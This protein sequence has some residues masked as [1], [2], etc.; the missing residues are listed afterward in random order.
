MTQEI[1]YQM[2]LV[3]DAR[4]LQKA[5]RASWK[6]CDNLSVCKGVEIEAYQT[7]LVEART[8]LAELEETLGN[9]RLLEVDRYIAKNKRRWMRVRSGVR[10]ILSADYKLLVTLTFTDDCLGSTTAETR[11][12][13]VRKYLAS[14]SDRYIANRDFGKQNGREHYHAIVRAVSIDFTAWKHGTVNAKPINPRQDKK[15]ACSRLSKYIDKL[16]AHAVKDTAC[17]RLIWSRAPKVLEAD[18]EE[19]SIDEAIDWLDELGG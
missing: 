15:E 5:R 4:A 8:A 19:M 10:S 13:Y 7:A 1:E 9:D 14:Q 3:A 12:T 17:D 16:T 6:A 11:R 18:Y 2:A